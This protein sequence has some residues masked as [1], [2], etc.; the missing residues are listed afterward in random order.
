MQKVFV[1]PAVSET[2]VFE[3]IITWAESSWW[4]DKLPMEIK[5]ISGRPGKNALYLQR[6][7]FVLGP[8]WKV[9]ESVI[10]TERK[11][12]KRVFLDGVFKGGYEEVFIDFEGGRK[13]CYNFFCPISNLLFGVLWDLVFRKLHKKSITRV[14]KALKKHIEEK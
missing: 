13:V 14:L 9:R 8:R 5:R 1:N 12:L 7:K 6:A 10:D 3:E 4:P 2:Q 11:Y